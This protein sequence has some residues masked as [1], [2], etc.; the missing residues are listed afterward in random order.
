MYIKG[1]NQR[2]IE[3]LTLKNK[4]FI[5]CQLCVQAVNH[6]YAFGQ[7]ILPQALCLLFNELNSI[8]SLQRLLYSISSSRSGFDPSLNL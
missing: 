4:R 5:G 2:L 6:E 8:W 7:C 1:V 3:F